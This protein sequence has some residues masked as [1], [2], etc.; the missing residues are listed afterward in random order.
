MKKKKEKKK[1][2]NKRL[3]TISLRVCVLQILLEDYFEDLSTL[4]DDTGYL[5]RI[6][7]LMR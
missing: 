1:N 5:M 3:G 4:F 7:I 6:I 2:M